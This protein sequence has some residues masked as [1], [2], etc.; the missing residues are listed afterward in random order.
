[1]RED[2]FLYLQASLGMREDRFS[3]LFNMLKTVTV[4]Q[5][6]VQSGAIGSLHIC[7]LLLR[8]EF[9]TLF[10]ASFQDMILKDS[11]VRDFDV[12]TG[13]MDTL[14]KTMEVTLCLIESRS[15][16]FA[17]ILLVVDFNWIFKMFMIFLQKS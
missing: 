7:F 2:R 13:S 6:F 3:F 17:T 14:L 16:A 8:E 9:K 4:M 5:T 1:M 11:V 15:L 10:A 12:R